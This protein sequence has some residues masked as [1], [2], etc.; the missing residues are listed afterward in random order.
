MP[1]QNY[2]GNSGQGGISMENPNSSGESSCGGL[3]NLSKFQFIFA[4]VRTALQLSTLAGSLT[5]TTCPG[6]EF[7]EIYSLRHLET[8]NH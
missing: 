3:G 1:M 2:Q 6:K 5:V 4:H 7:L 8:E